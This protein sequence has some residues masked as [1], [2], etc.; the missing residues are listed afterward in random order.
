MSKRKYVDGDESMGKESKLRI[1]SEIEEPAQAMEQNEVE[2][3]IDLTED[4]SPA[5]I[6]QLNANCYREMLNWLLLND[7]NA[8]ARTCK[9][10]QQMVGKHVHQYYPNVCARYEN[11][12]CFTS[13][14]TVNGEMNGLLRFVRK[15]KIAH[16]NDNPDVEQLMY[17]GSKCM[18]S[19]EGICFVNVC[20]TAAKMQYI[21]SILGQVESIKIRKCSMDG[22]FYNDF[23][24]LAPNLKRISLNLQQSGWEIPGKCVTFN[25]HWTTRKFP[26]LEYVEFLHGGRLLKPFL[27]Q[28]PSIRTLVINATSFWENRVWIMKS[29]VKL[30]D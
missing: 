15:I 9:T 11:G 8:L 10:M 30:D 16:E 18:E 2:N 7:L 27:K 12:K 22:D 25:S 20:F 19:I 26:A 29:Q 5:K 21:K 4:E 17:F 28:N 14:M 24:K 3:A 23:L 6:L 1:K 13:S